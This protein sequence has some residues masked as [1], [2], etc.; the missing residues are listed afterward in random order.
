VS[1]SEVASRVN[2]SLSTVIGYLEAWIL[3][4]SWEEARTYVGALVSDAVYRRVEEAI[5]AEGPERLAPLKERVG[6]E[7]DYQ[8]LRIAR[9]WWR[10]TR[11]VAG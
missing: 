10:R 4:A 8:T 1:L 3:V 9:A 7:V 11:E 5:R 6:D 2:R